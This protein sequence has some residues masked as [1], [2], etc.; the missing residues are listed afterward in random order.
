M[1]NGVLDEVCLLM[2]SQRTW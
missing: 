2:Y 1:K